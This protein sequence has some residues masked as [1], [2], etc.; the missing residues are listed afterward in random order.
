MTGSEPTE[1][2]LLISHLHDQFWSEQYYLAAQ[3]VRQ[4]SGGGTA[5]WAGPVF[6][7][8]HKELAPRG[9]HI[10]GVNLDGKEGTI[11][12]YIDKYDVDYPVLKGDR[13]TQQAWI[14]SKSWATV[15]VSSWIEGV[16]CFGPDDLILRQLPI[17]GR[18][19]WRESKSK[20]RHLKRYDVFQRCVDTRV[21]RRIWDFLFD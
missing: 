2:A 5:D 7:K 8:L 15:F 11:R 4:W 17:E 16:E 18:Y 13:T 14:G 9:L 3:L 6:T 10:V 19:H 21:P 12:A 20:V 1:R